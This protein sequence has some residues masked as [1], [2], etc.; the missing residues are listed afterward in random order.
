[1]VR[2]A[3]LVKAPPSSSPLWKAWELLTRFNVVAYRLTGGRIGGSYAGAPI[4]LL[5]HRGAR[6][7]QERVSPLLYLADGDDMVIVASKGGTDRHPAWFHNLRAHPDAVVEVGRERRPVRARVL[8]GEERARMWDR[9][10]ELYGHYESY[11]RH[12]GERQIPL[13]VLEPAQR[14]P[15]GNGGGGAESSRRAPQARQSS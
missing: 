4:L 8:E 2:L 6:S 14:Q 1:V 11:Q 9:V 12:A 7:G 3:S 10:V 5:H 13:V 15:G